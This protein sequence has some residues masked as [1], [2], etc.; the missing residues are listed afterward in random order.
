MSNPLNA[1]PKPPVQPSEPTAAA[2]LP[3]DVAAY[4]ADML[5]DLRDL[6][7]RSGHEVLHDLLDIAHRVATTPSIPPMLDRQRWPRP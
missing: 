3:A 7:S 4:I 5:D 1:L 2:A 6:A